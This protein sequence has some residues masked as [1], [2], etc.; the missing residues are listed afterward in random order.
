MYVVGNGMYDLQIVQ[1]TDTNIPNFQNEVAVTFSYTDGEIS[2]LDESSIMPFRWN[3]SFWD[4]IHGG[5][6]ADALNNTITCQTDQF[7]TFGLFGYMNEIAQSF[8]GKAKTLRRRGMA[9][10]DFRGVAVEGGVNKS[11]FETAYQNSLDEI[12]MINAGEA[13]G[14]QVAINEEG[15]KVFL[16]Y[17]AGRS[18]VQQIEDTITR[19]SAVAYRGSTPRSSAMLARQ[20]AS[21]KS[22]LA[23][24]KGGLLAKSSVQKK[25]EEEQ[26][27]ALSMATKFDKTQSLLQMYQMA[28]EEIAL[29]LSQGAGFC[30]EIYRYLASEIAS[31]EKEMIDHLMQNN[32]NWD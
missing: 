15:E 7:S 32:S 22:R 25:A 21:L 30:D 11:N 31:R 26:E 5:C 14:A 8:S 13:G 27:L 20:D 9:R 28:N 4:T 2:M 16:G 29:C 19:R 12:A 3:G 24:M 23:K 1:D 17:K 6:K 18:G 10:E